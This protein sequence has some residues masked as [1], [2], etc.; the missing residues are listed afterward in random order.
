MARSGKGN[1][2]IL[3]AL[4]AYAL[5][6]LPAKEALLVVLFGLVLALVALE[7][8][9]NITFMFSQLAKVL[10]YFRVQPQNHAREEVVKFCAAIDNYP[11]F[12]N[13]LISRKKKLFF[14]MPISQQNQA[15]D[16]YRRLKDVEELMAENGVFLNQLR[17]YA[18]EKFNIS[19]LE[20]SY[21]ARSRGGNACIDLIEHFVRDYSSSKRDVESRNE[22]FSPIMK[23]L[24]TQLKNNTP[25]Q[26]VLLPGSGLGRLGLEISKQYPQWEVD[27]IELSGEMWLGSQFATELKSDATLYPHLT[28]FSNWRNGKD[29]LAG[30]KVELPGPNPNLKTLRYEYGN[31][32]EYNSLETYDVITTLFFI[33]TAQ[34]VFDYIDKIHNLLSKNGVWL[35]YGPIKWG[36]AAYAELSGDE[37]L[38][39]LKRNGWKVQ[40]VWDNGTNRYNG[41]EDSMVISRYKL[42]GWAARKL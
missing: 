20:I 29:Q 5:Y 1:L 15:V 25:H 39:Y 26:R 14:M 24:S 12:A 35:N 19:P 13:S 23:Y 38:N 28:Y 2:F 33:D 22:L 9:D 21:H 17:K 32:L 7:Y 37:I 40:E 34:N 8:R 27:C 18:V 6:L 10:L 30:S 16:T 3:F 41:S 31:F 42:I 36:T 4:L 11:A